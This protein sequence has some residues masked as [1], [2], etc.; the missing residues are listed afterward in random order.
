[1]PHFA[2]RLYVRFM[3]VYML[4]LII[5]IGHYDNTALI[6]QPQNQRILQK[7]NWHYQRNSFLLQI[8]Q[9]KVVPSVYILYDCIEQVFTAS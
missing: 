2:L 9:T 5:R 3:A 8:K 4:V 7:G 6:M 1:M